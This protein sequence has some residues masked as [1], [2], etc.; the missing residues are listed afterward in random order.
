MDHRNL[1]EG[2]CMIGRWVDVKGNAGL[3]ENGVLGPLPLRGATK[4]SHWG[5]GPVILTMV[6]MLSSE[7]RAEEKVQD[8]DLRAELAWKTDCDP[9]GCFFVRVGRGRRPGADEVEDA[10]GYRLRLG[11]PSEED[12]LA[13]F[14]FRKGEAPLDRAR[15]LLTDI[16]PMEFGSLDQAP[17][18]ALELVCDEEACV[19]GVQIDQRLSD[20]R[21]VRRHLGSSRWLFL[22]YGD[23][24]GPQ[25]HSMIS[26]GT[27]QEA[28]EEAGRPLRAPSSAEVNPP[29]ASA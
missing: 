26:L 28:V 14:I 15:L 19:G 10:V 11:D 22:F 12:H 7:G 3:N 23:E 5:W 21:S 1:A 24:E 25:G 18:L 13:I 27:L 17:H 2:V 29:T 6:L 4:R 9:A 16:G 20:G 8:E